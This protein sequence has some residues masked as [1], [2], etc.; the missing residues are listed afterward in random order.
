M[1]TFRIILLLLF[2]VTAAQADGPGDNLPDSVRRIPP[3]GI[4]VSTADRA[5]LEAGVKELGDQIGS[6]RALLKTRPELLDL[7]PDVQIYHNAVRYALA[8]NEFFRDREISTAK[9]LLKQG[10][11]RAALLRDGKAPW[12]AETGL[13]VRGYVSKIDGSVQPY[14]LV[15]PAS[16]RPDAPYQH[17]LDVWFHGRDE[18][19]SELNFIN[20]RQRSPGEFTPANAFVLHPYGR[21][22]NANR[23]AGEVDTL[24]A[25]DH[26]RRHYPI[27][28]NRISVRGF[29]MGGA[30]CWQFAVHYAGQWAAA[31]PG[32]GFTET[33]DF[34]KVFQNETVKPPWY[35]QKLWHLYDSIDDAINLSNC[36][37][38]AYSGELDAQKQAADQ[39]AAALHREGIE[40]VHVIGP[41][42]RHAYEPHAKEEVS[43]RIDLIAN[44]GRN[45][46]PHRVRFTTWTLRYNQMCWLQLDGL[47]H[48]W[49]RARVDAEISDPNT[50]TIK[51]VNVTALTLTMPP[52]LCPLDETRRPTVVL[53]G[54]SLTAAPVLSDR[55]WT[56]HFRK[57]GSHW[58]A[59][60]SAD[61]GTLRK[62]PGLQ[63]PIDDA[64]MDSFL[65][66]RPTG[67]P[68]NAKTGAWVTAE[69]AHA[70]EHWRRQFR[71][72]ARVK[73]DLD[74]SEDD[75]ASSN[76]ILWGDPSSNKLLARIAG[77][78]PIRWSASALQA[79]ARTYPAD[80]HVPV[81]IYPNPLN[82]TRY[83][84]LNSGFTFREYDYLNNARQTPKIPDYALVDISVPPSSRAPGGIVDA[85]FFDERW[86][87]TPAGEQAGRP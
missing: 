11:E 45:P 57:E 65:M 67:T 14:G 29:S 85:G 16:Y 64:F 71:G 54:Q 8:Y 73:D 13:V 9:A 46:L 37:T 1:R 32:A 72:E 5:E 42:T 40:M 18:T 34:L 39:M 6:L 21:Y 56:A 31:A 53:D 7:L 66:V 51:T 36:P 68:L 76:L 43:R 48:H 17:R 83:V 70:V 74:V 86:Q 30:S 69:M 59:A 24:E 77:K 84:V 79:G 52:G 47:E 4:A 50:V 62:R 33:A 87:W 25:L 19:L 58:S 55:S 44:R 26:V 12:A 81:L 2:I 38:V 23:F 22:C 3:P 15:V 78:L 10:M 60:G 75:I 61:D 27:D 20:G 41:R 82:P 28:E 63:G 35:Q 49:E 80:H